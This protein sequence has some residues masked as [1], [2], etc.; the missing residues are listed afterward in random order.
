MFSQLLN[1]HRIF[2]RLAKALSDCTYVQANLRL[3][4]VAHIILLEI[5]IAAHFDFYREDPVCDFKYNKDMKYMVLAIKIQSFQRN[6][7]YYFVSLTE[8]K[9]EMSFFVA[10]ILCILV[11]HKRA[12]WQTVKTCMKC[13]KMWHFIWVYTFCL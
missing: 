2:K 13:H 8:A 12:L 4:W 7:K 6:T 1:T 5:S 11:T 10:L 3:C 9:F